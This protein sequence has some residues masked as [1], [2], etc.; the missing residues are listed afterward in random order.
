MI[1]PNGLLSLK[2]ITLGLCD[3]IDCQRLLSYVL[4]RH[5]DDGGFTS[6]PMLESSVEDTYFAVYILDSL[7]QLTS[8]IANGVLKYLHTAN[9][10]SIKVVYFLVKTLENLDI[11]SKEHL[12]LATVALA[13]INESR[14]TTMPASTETSVNNLVGTERNHVDMAFKSIDLEKLTYFEMPTKL[15]SI[16][17]TIYIY[18]RLGLPLDKEQFLSAIFKFKNSDGGFGNRRNSNIEE[19]YYAVMAL[20]ELDYP[21][22]ELRDTLTWLRKCENEDGGFN[23]TPITII[24]P[25][26]NYTYYGVRA[27]LAFDEVPR[28]GREILRNV[29][30]FQNKNGGFRRYIRHGISRTINTYQ[31]VWI[32]KNLGTYFY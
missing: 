12:Q 13:T 5:N 31:A 16:F 19:T 21:I 1:F 15:E 25:S 28:Y 11:M 29:R 20:K 26:L 14:T 10:S 7:G 8:D 18:K 30:K 27:I 22:D 32:V 9:I 17:E 2:V 4:E 6:V 3:V 23:I 24:E